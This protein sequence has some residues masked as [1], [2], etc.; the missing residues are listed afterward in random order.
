MLA[1]ASA[2]RSSK[3]MVIR[4]TTWG[5]I[6]LSADDPALRSNSAQILGGPGLGKPRLPVH[7]PAMRPELRKP[8]AVNHCQKPTP[9]H[10]LSTRERKQRK[11]KRRS[12]APVKPHSRRLMKL[13]SETEMSL[14]EIVK[15]VHCTLGQSSKRPECSAG[16]M[17]KWIDLC[18]AGSTSK[19]FHGMSVC[20]NTKFLQETSMSKIKFYKR[21]F[22][23]DILEISGKAIRA[24]KK[25]V[26]IH[27]QI[28]RIDVLTDQFDDKVLI[29]EGNVTFVTPNQNGAIVEVPRL[30]TSS[31]RRLAEQ[32]SDQRRAKYR[33]NFFTD[34]DEKTWNKFL[35]KYSI[36]RNGIDI[37]KTL[38]EFTKVVFPGHLNPNDNTFGGQ[39]LEWVEE[40]SYLSAALFAKQRTVRCTEISAN[41][42]KLTTSG[43]VLVFKTK[44]NQVFHRNHSLVVGCKIVRIVDK[45]PDKH[46]K[47]Q[48]I[49]QAT[50]TFSVE[51]LSTLSPVF[52]KSIGDR[53]AFY[54]ATEEY[55]IV[56]KSM[57]G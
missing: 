29:G 42:K 9:D 27:V 23:G 37:A 6:G 2:F 52:P 12:D 45:G 8:R 40:T 51:N 55:G 15:S 47:H 36:S 22:Q 16:A 53:F 26:V 57:E 5:W 14:T 41:F 25:S 32:A 34:G 10:F 3:E 4:K 38:R 17:L 56:L 31:I 49:G 21:V 13:P 1:V 46:E 30:D 48:T 19:F 54:Q 39:L 20:S 44:I 11:T 43:D 35:V 28:N 33:G 18:A 50:L 7:A 24:F